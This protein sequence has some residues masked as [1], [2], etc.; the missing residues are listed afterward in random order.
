MSV[1]VTRTVRVCRLTCNID[2]KLLASQPGGLNVT[3][4]GLAF[5]ALH[6]MHK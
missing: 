2:P 5:P 1:P 4:S 3:V 6:Q